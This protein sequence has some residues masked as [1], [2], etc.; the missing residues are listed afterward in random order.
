M[1]ENR[2]SDNKSRILSITKLEA[3]TSFE[4]PK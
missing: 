4:I 2:D 3:D 1:I